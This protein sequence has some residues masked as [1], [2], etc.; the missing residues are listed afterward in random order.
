MTT[1][2]QQLHLSLT[3][4]QIEPHL[5][6]SPAVPSH[7]GHIFGG[8][9]M[10]Q[11]LSAASRTVPAERHAHSLHA[12]FL[13]SGDDNKPVQFH[14]ESLRDGGSFSTRQVLAEQDEKVILHATVSYKVPEPGPIRQPQMPEIP[15]PSSLMTD[16]ERRRAEGLSFT[17][18][19]PNPFS[20]FEMRTVGPLPEQFTAGEGDTQG[21]WMKAA[22]PA[23]DSVLMQQCLLA[24]VSDFRL[25]CSSMKPH[26]LKFHDENLQYGSLDHSLWFHR[27]FRF[28]DWFYYDLV[29]AV[30]ADARGLN[31]GRLYDSNGQL[32]ASTAQ[33]GLMRVK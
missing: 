16:Q 25:M 19:E 22:S 3:P 18:A 30:S 9:A 21:V 11:A 20:T 26:G 17:F 1:P 15:A 13:R 32:I 28:D 29:G 14:V 27:P 4:E 23:S 6:S 7:L 2:T 12:R 33:E 5:F 8:Q 24:Y 31:F 10:A